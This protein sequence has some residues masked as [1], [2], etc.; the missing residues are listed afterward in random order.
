MREEK[1]FTVGVLVSGIMDEFTK[2]VCKGVFQVAKMENVDV[3]VFPGKYLERDL[4]DNR[5]L[6]YEYQYSTVFSYA[7]IK[8]V[9]ALI[10]A[11]GCIGCFASENAIE[12][13]L[14]QYEGIP[15]V[16]IASKIDGYLS[17]VFD[18]YQ[19]IKEGLEY[20]TDKK[21]CKNF[22]MI[23]GSVENLDARERKQAFKE[24]LNSRQI[25]FKETMYVEG[26]FS[27]RCTQAYK[28]L[29]DENPEIEAIFCANDEMAMG[30]YEELRRRGLQAGKDISVFGY[31]DT[32]AAAKAFP[33]LSS[34]RAD[35]GRLGEEAMKIA[36]YLMRGETT[37][38][39]V[40]PTRFV[41]RDSIGQE[42]TEEEEEIQYVKDIDASFADI[43]YR[44]LHEEM[45]DEM[46][47]LRISYGKLIQTLTQSFQ[48]SNSDLIKYMDIALCADE[49]LNFGG[50]E[51]ADID[52]L[53]NALEELYRKIR[54]KQLDDRKKHELREIF[55]VIYR[56]I[57][58]AM[59]YQL[60]SMKESKYNE[61]YVMKL[62]VQNM[63][64]FEKGKDQ[65]YSSLLENLDW[66]H[67][68]NACIYMLPNPILHLFKEQFKVPDV[69]YLKAV[70]SDGKVEYIPPIQQKTKLENIFS[71]SKMQKNKWGER[72]VLPLFFN[73]MVYGILLC[74]M[75]E[76]LFTNGEF[77]INQISSAIKMIL[78]LEANE[79][80][81]QQLEENVAALKSHNIELDTISK[82]D[83]LT[84]IWNRRGFIEEAEKRISKNHGQEGV[85]LV[86]YADMNNL[87]IINDRYG[88]EEGDYSLKLI[89]KILGE[90]VSDKGVAGRIGGD[91]YACVVE[92][93]EE[94][95]GTELIGEIYRKMETYNKK[96]SKPYNITVSAGTYILKSESGVT[97]KE[98]LMQAD[99]ELYK[100]KQHRKKEVAKNIL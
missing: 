28:K 100:V 71:N 80:T 69:L 78:L 79:N 81:Q 63:L 39:A 83:V 5:E 6:M 42:E 32:I 76:D 64:Q 58:R 1:R 61:S 26:D 31:D 82:L 43:F 16:L 27:R 72:V 96:S 11:A 15:C 14:K 99:E 93:N 46:N 95:N 70:L 23:G 54:E 38:D 48:R 91:E 47:R 73:E 55:S 77:L 29:L 30:L 50:V 41:K 9:D 52:N 40:I 34:V 87:K 86:V 12:N 57:I 7:Q 21:G 8:N 59:N 85:F 62:F 37:T 66:L 49:F 22:G 53:L 17:A 90:M 18:N 24:V 45:E 88:H 94:D 25:E 89:G 67:I 98:A 4:S 68:K 51:Y 35:S 65:S 97:L 56:K 92:Y 74:D 60:G 44:Y 2:Y 84:G 20:L 10:I 19:G 13:I 36:L 33:P 75:T 3:V